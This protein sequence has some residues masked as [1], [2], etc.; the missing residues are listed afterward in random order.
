VAVIFA[1]NGSGGWEAVSARYASLFSDSNRLIPPGSAWTGHS[2]WGW[3]WADIA[4]LL[5]FGGIP[6]QVY[7]QRVLACR[8]E[9]S[10]IRLSVLAGFGCLLAAV[11]AAMI[12]VIGG[13]TDWAALHVDPPSHPALTL[14]WVLLHLTPHLVAVLGLAAIAAAVMSSVDSSILSASSMFAWNIYRPFLSRDGRDQSIA[15]VTRIAI[16]VVGSAATALALAVQSVYTLWAL[17]SD[18]VYV[19]LFPQLLMALFDRR[20]TRAGA[21]C[22]A[23]VAIV[24]R[25]GGGE[26]LLGIDPVLPYPMADPERGLLFPFRTFAMI[27]GLVTIWVV[28]RL[29]TT[30]RFS[31]TGGGSQPRVD[32]DPGVP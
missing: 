20:V 6:W 7:F 19:I 32:R 12:G 18:L 10:A 24:L 21:V 28:S 8:D 31:Q 16:A 25:L 1:L 11:P 2:P 29:R 15:R 14:P 26:P 4:L 27:S 22:G 23:L 5:V 13:T 3:Q 17:C 30:G 9:G